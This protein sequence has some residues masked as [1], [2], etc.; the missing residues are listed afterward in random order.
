MT[1]YDPPPLTPEQELIQALTEAMAAIVGES[2]SLA[3]VRRAV[4]LLRT[5]NP[6]IDRLVRE[7][8]EVLYLL[9]LARPHLPARDVSSDVARRFLD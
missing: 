5:G 6:G 2:P 7:H 3:E 8:A 9:V 1:N 4:R